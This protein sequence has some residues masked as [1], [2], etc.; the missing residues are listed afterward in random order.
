MGGSSSQLPGDTNPG[1]GGDLPRRWAALKEGLR[2]AAVSIGPGTPA[3]EDRGF[4]PGGGW[5]SR[6]ACGG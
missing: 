4:Y 1:G 2:G 3:G 5:C 6:R